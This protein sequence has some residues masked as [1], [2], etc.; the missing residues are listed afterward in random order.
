MCQLFPK[1]YVFE[2]KIT[3]RTTDENNRMCLKDT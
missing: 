1:L 2:T 3:N